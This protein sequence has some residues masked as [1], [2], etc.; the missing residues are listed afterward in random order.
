MYKT[1]VPV[2]ASANNVWATTQN[3]KE[4]KGMKVTPRKIFALFFLIVLA[5][6]F[7]SFIPNIKIVAADSPLIFY[8]NFSNGL[9]GWSSTG[10][11]YGGSIS[12]E[13]GYPD[14]NNYYCNTTLAGTHNGEAWLTA[15]IA[16]PD[17]VYSFGWFYI[18]ALNIPDGHFLE[19]ITYDSGPRAES[20]GI[21]NS[22]GILYWC[23][24]VVGNNGP[25]FYPSTITPSLN[26]FHSVEVERSNSSTLESLWIDGSMITSATQ[27]FSNPTAQVSFG[28]YLNVA[29]YNSFF[30]TNC[31]VSSSY[32]DPSAYPVAPTPGP[33]GSITISP[34]SQT[35]SAGVSQVY[36]AEE[37]DQY[38]NGLGSVAASYSV[39]G[40]AIS[41]DS[42]TE[43]VAGVYTVAASYDGLTADASLTVTAG[44]L[45]SISISPV[46]QTVAVGV[47][48]VY[49]AVGFDEY[50]N[51]LGSV[52]ASYS[53]NG[54]A[55]SGDSVTETVAGV[56]TVEASYGGFVADASLTVD[57]GQLGYSGVG[58]GVVYCGGE[59]DCS[60]LATSSG[61]SA[62][63]SVYFQ[64]LA[65]AAFS[66]YFCI[67][68]QSGVLLGSVQVPVG[69][70]DSAGWKTATL[71]GVS[72]V[73]G[74]YYRLAVFVP[75][76]GYNLL[77]FYSSGAANQQRFAGGPAP[78]PTT[79][80]STGGANPFEMSMYVT[81]GS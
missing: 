12:V 43:T 71:S 7:L 39:N 37:F 44:P 23:L 50:G 58:S 48:Q 15:N 3:E 24:Y 67:Y 78:P 66:P 55:I 18:T 38:G 2:S 70:P 19:M 33:L 81:F 64:N 69:Y 79:L 60:F 61:T 75:A 13:T 46:S 51:G 56:Y 54:V 72:I 25:I 6:S 42:V 77:M 4:A 11:Q 9:A 52:A 20:A 41:G 57:A 34:V 28:P 59:L 80:G 21:Y 17:P 5:M 40:V 76:G 65:G 26:T 36:A 47:S 45:A 62:T 30:F 35:V 63:M 29:G 14:S 32:V 49:S 22:S 73:A 68:S 10:T 74:D 1:H 8:S 31:V 16:N 53:V 27:F